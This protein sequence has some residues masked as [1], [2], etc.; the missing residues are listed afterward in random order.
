[1]QSPKYKK[2]FQTGI[3]GIHEDHYVHLLKCIIPPLSSKNSMNIP[4]ASI[5]SILDYEHPFSTIY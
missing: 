3:L 4:N 2:E 1:M 5:N